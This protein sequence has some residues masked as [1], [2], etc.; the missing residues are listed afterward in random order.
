MEKETN[1]I[2]DKYVESVMKLV[3]RKPHVWL[4]L[5]WNIFVAAGGQ[6]CKDFSKIKEALP[7]EVTSPETAL[8][9]LITEV[10]IMH[11]SLA[12][13]EIIDFCCHQYDSQPFTYNSLHHE[14]SSLAR[15]MI[16]IADP[17]QEDNI[18]LPFSGM[19]EIASMLP[20]SAVVSQA[21]ELDP[22]IWA[23][24]QIRLFLHRMLFDNFRKTEAWNFD[25]AD[26]LERMTEMVN[27]L[28]TTL[29]HESNFEGDTYG[30]F[31]LIIMSP[32]TGV[33]PNKLG[34]FLHVK[35]VRNAFRLLKRT[36]R[37][38]VAIPAEYLYRQSIEHLSNFLLGN[39]GLKSI[40]FIPNANLPTSF[41]DVC[42]LEITREHN[43]EV[44]LVDASSFVDRHFK[45]GELFDSQ[46]VAALRHKT[47]DGTNVKVVPTN[48]L[49]SSNLLPGV[50]IHQEEYT[51]DTV[52][53][54]DCLAQNQV[55]CEEMPDAPM[56]D[57]N[58][59]SQH[60]LNCNIF[61]DKLSKPSSTRLKYKMTDE[62]TLF[63]SFSRDFRIGVFTPSNETPK[64]CWCLYHLDAFRVDESKIMF[65]YLLRELTS[66]RMSL[67]VSE[68]FSGRWNPAKIKAFLDLTIPLPSK[69]EQM[70]IVFEET[71][72]N[73]SGA[74]EA[75][76]RAQDQHVIDIRLRK[77]TL[78]SNVGAYRNQWKTLRKAF[79]RSGGIVDLNKQVTRAYDDNFFEWM[80][81]M[82]ALFEEINRELKV[83]TDTKEDFGE[84]IAENPDELIAQYCDAKKQTAYM[85]T[86]VEEVEPDVMICIPEKALFRVFDNIVNN[87][88]SH[89]FTDPEREDYEIRFQTIATAE[90]VTIIVANNGTPLSK[91]IQPEEVFE[92]GRSTRMYKDTHG[93]Q[94]GYDIRRILSQYD[95][96]VNVESHPDSEFTVVYKLNF[97]RHYE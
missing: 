15:L 63:V 6:R 43:E 20:E 68:I 23:M 71:R 65:D 54:G 5:A 85:L 48:N 62:K 17:R 41:G 26:S 36:G 56:I 18:Y 66:K 58:C 88:L 82:E 86:T 53:L 44:V 69:E 10:E 8:N 96:G 47:S 89:G 64:I 2:I 84:A 25:N 33:D 12:T 94:G 80:D 9:Q 46:T 37:M 78:I 1:A 51:G 73:L 55:R 91:E 97:K 61:T 35:A 95:A 75:L 57:D 60:Y 29:R 34:T 52:R 67:K 83:L 3:Q 38:V 76:V 59:L 81:G 70:K 28:S 79:D 45:N 92:L 14:S 74:Q 32:P 27:S 4:A 72:S 19:G 7:P 11:L 31:D 87:A 40:T 13:K 90:S 39:G 30:P 93:G 49:A 21:E 22:I 77:H 16:E 50:Y 24:G 42:V